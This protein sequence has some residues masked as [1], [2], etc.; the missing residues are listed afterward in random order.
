MWQC[1]K[2]R[3]SIEN[4]FGVCW[5]CGTSKDGVED[6]TFQQ[7]EESVSPTS[8]AA[9]EFRQPTVPAVAEP[10]EHANQSAERRAR[11]S[12][13]VDSQCPHCGGADLVRAV[14]LSQP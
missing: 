3:E 4:S 6:P 5:N 8:T 2:C 11:P 7:V 9:L 10:H 14:M 13:A 1:A 12:D